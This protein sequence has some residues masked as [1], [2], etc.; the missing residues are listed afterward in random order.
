MARGTSLMAFEV[1]ESIPDSFWRITQQCDGAVA[2]L[3][4]Q[5]PDDVG[6]VAVVNACAFSLLA[7]LAL[8][9]VLGTKSLEL[10]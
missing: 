9:L 8:P 5:S 3:A 10:R 2:F 7:Y 4:D 6:V 1:V